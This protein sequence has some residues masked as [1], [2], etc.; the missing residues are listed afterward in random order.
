MKSWRTIPLATVLA[1][2]GGLLGLPAGA[3][4][5]SAT[6]A[7]AQAEHRQPVLLISI[8]GMKPEAVFEADKHGLKLPVL[9]SF[10]TKGSYA[11]RVINVNPTVTSPNHTTL[12]TGVTPREHGIYNNRPFAPTEKLPSGYSLYSQIK[13]PTLWGAAKSAGMV[14][15]AIFWPVTLGAGDIDFNL[16]NGSDEDDDQ[17]ANDAIALLENERPE[18]LTVHFVSHDHEAHKTG[19]FSPEANIAL[20]RIDAAVGR[21]IDAQWKTFPNSVVMIAS[22]HGFFTVSHQVN[23]NTALVEAGFI[24]LNDNPGAS[25]EQSVAAWKAFVWYV[26]GMG[27]VV[28]HDPKDQ[29][30][31]SQFETFLYNL[32]GNPENGIER[33]YRRDELAGRGLAPEA[34]MVVA[35]KEGYRMGNSLRGPRVEP[36]VGGAHGAFSTQ[37][38]RPD[39]HSSFFIR[40]PGIVAGK[41]LGTIDMRQIAPTIAGK[42]QIAFPSAK[43]PPLSLSDR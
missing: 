23:T 20:E 38:I 2:A 36:F 21:L 34:D 27:M 30:T 6:E 25:P 7:A 43:Q 32:A 22:D 11:E 37:T 4:A 29:Q 26:G 18:F 16:R 12:V 28:L 31:R 42:L 15:G 19:P 40:G 33:V 17:I 3:N 8:D 39:M 14:T 9:R 13:A 41:N 5:A 35:F 10:V 24:T 1:L